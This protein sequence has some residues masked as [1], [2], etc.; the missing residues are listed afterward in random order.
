MENSIS[1]G[2]GISGDILARLI[3]KQS[4]QL[5]IDNKKLT[6]HLSHF[7]NENFR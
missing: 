1:I 4:R 6:N 2:N 5:V 7:I 3:R